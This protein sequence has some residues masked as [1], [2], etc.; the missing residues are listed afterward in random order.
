ML[1]WKPSFTIGVT[2][3]DVQHKMLFK[4]A[5]RFEGAVHAREPIF[6]LEELFTFLADYVGA[7]FAAEEQLMRDVGYPELAEHAQEH[8]EFK[9]R[10]QSLVP[11]LESEE[12]STALLPELRGLLHFW[13]TDHVTSRDQRIGDFLKDH[14]SPANRS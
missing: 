6:R 4:R 10:L 13:L 8:S 11:Q 14:G 5:A 1:P 9:R 3:L 12:D 2:E 7:Q